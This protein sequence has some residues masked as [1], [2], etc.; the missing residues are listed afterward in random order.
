MLLKMLGAQVGVRLLGFYLL[1]PAINISV[2]ENDLGLWVGFDEFFR[3]ADG[4]RV[5][6]CLYCGK[7]C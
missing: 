6:Y 4:W 7:A 1:V 2:C 5:S 3:K